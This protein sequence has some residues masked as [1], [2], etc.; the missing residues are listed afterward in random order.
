MSK[1]V[2][3]FLTNESGTTAIEYALMAGSIAVVIIGTVNTV[4]SQLTATFY[5]KI[6]AAFK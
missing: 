2:L 3:R 5:T 4:G 6:S 1:L